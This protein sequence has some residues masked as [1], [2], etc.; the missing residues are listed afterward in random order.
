V[1]VS[2]W[3]PSGQHD[4]LL[5]ELDLSHIE[6]AVDPLGRMA[7]AM[8]GN[9]EPILTPRTPYSVLVDGDGVVLGRVDGVWSDEAA[10]SL[11]PA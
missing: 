2:S 10:A 8:N 6:L 3:D 11:P 4:R 5:G 9:V 1:A 7:T